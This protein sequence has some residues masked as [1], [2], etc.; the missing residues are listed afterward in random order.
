MRNIF[1]MQTCLQQAGGNLKVDSLSHNYNMLYDWST[2]RLV[3]RNLLTHMW[4]WNF[5]AEDMSDN[6]KVHVF[7]S[8]YWYDE[9]GN[10]IRK[11]KYQ[12]V[13]TSGSPDLEDP[14]QAEPVGEEESGSWVFVEAIYY[15]RDIAGREIAIYSGNKLEQCTKGV[16]SGE[17]VRI[18]QR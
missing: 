18:R 3:E 16:P 10:R 15:I 14:S 11:E 2:T 9:A 1:M 12:W 7:M 8:Q 13:L 17:H 5:K 6:P 4:H